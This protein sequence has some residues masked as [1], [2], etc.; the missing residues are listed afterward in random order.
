MA[1][2]L[3]LN[4][5]AGNYC[6]K[7]PYMVLLYIPILFALIIWIKKDMIAFKNAKEQ[8]EYTA[9]RKRKRLIMTISRAIIL[10]FLI[11]A[12]ASPYSTQEKTVPGD[13]SL[14]MLVDN[15]TSFDIFDRAVVEKL[16]Q[17]LRN[18]IPVNVRSVAS[19]DKSAIGDG[20][21][22]YVHGDDNVLLVSD[23]NNNF[24]R[25]LG[26][27]VLF[28]SSLNTT[29]N[30]L[31]LNP[32]KNDIG[33]YIE[34]PSKVITDTE[35][36]FVVK[37]N[38]VGNTG[39]YSLEIKVDGNAVA[40]E[41]DAESKV[42]TE[43]FSE[44]YHTFTATLTP[45][46]DDYFPENNIF[47]KTVKV[48]PRPKLLFVTAGDSP[49]AE[50]LGRIYDVEQKGTLPEDISG[51]AAVILN[52]I[53]SSDVDPYM[54]RITDYVAE[55]GNGLIA[56]G[57]KNSYDKGVYQKS[58]I[59]ALLPVFVGTGKK[60]KDSDMNVVVVM[61]ISES[62]GLNFNSASSNT[63]TDVEKAIALNVLDDFSAEQN[64]GFVAFN[65]QAYMVSQLSPFNE[66]DDLI[67]KIL[68]LRD[69]GGTVVSTGLRK[70][71]F[72]LR[73]AKGSKNIV[74]IS[75]GITQQPED[76]LQT[77]AQFAAQGIHTYTVSVG[78]HSNK[79]FMKALAE[80]GKGVYFEPSET[81]K[82]KIIFGTVPG[83]SEGKTYPLGIIDRNYDRNFALPEE[84]KL[85]AYVNGFNF[86]LPKSTAKTIVAT[87]ENSPIIAIWRFGLGRIVSFATDDGS[88][89]AGSLLKKENSP[90]LTKTINWAIGDLGRKKDYDVS[91]DD[92]SLNKETEVRVIAKS[93]PSAEGLEFIKVSPEQYQ[94]TFMPDS[95]GFKEL[96]GA[97]YAVN[98][99]DELLQLGVNPKLIDYVTATGGSFFNPE[100]VDKIVQKVETRSKRTKVYTMS[101]RW[102]FT[103]AALILLLLEYTYRRLKE[104]RMIKW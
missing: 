17:E 65:H 90:L 64:I 36:D 57:G 30:A 9:T 103:L 67:E 61:D 47:Y 93:P 87:N 63:V 33:V 42:I 76:A 98:Y 37:V 49:L 70:A 6:M 14:T 69:T 29:I 7:Y 20:I 74:V 34:G 88:K 97:T 13:A 72:M 77:A 3:A 101:Y 10:F 31:N 89:W 83:E 41:Q 16:E 50:G 62:T 53:R 94:A 43:K 45:A 100:D 99:N 86:V 12:I 95:T 82:L 56:I 22:N 78:G 38:K 35:N 75:D 92:A 59:E 54:D 26:D 52:D 18:R 81:Q 58:R 21:L 68:T 71:E 46:G 48:M 55:N 5:C 85:D 25:D 96:L 104:N 1:L 19:G 51:Y 66:K 23:A 73:D 39:S 80:K 11:L 8:E 91:V 15:S 32:I 84:F 102:I 40:T 2:N 27:M 28:A 24:G 4:L 79:D 60:N 44:G